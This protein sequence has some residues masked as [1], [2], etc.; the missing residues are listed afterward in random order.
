MHGGPGR[1][2]ASD[3]FGYDNLLKNWCKKNFKNQLEEKQHA[4]PV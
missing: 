2:F 1:Q 4:N 3:S